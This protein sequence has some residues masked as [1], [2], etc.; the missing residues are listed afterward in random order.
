MCLFKPGQPDNYELAYTPS[1][2]PKMIVIEIVS[3][4][5][6]PFEIC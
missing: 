6:L 3:E 4:P 5:L 1:P 2:L